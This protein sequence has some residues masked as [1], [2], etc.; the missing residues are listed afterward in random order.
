MI[1]D[2]FFGFL[3]D[4]RFISG[5]GSIH[6]DERSEPAS[7]TTSDERR[8][9]RKIAHS[10]RFCAAWTYFRRGPVRE[11]EPGGLSHRNCNLR[12]ADTH[13]FFICAAD[14]SA[15]G[16]VRV[17]ESRGGRNR[18]HRF[19]LAVRQV[20][21]V[22]SVRLRPDSPRSLA[23]STPS[24]AACVRGIIA[25]SPDPA[26]GFVAIASRFLPTARAILT[27]LESTAPVCADVIPSH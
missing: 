26:R 10:V 6:P 1:C 22:L 17:F 14:I 7:D 25:Y 19:T 21:D 23:L 27:V 4:Y 11:R 5:R 12:Q 24:P 16:R 2:S 18:A 9:R 8:S 3:H 20:L 15:L 13:I